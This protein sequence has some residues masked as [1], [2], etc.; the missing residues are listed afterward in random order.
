M[1]VIRTACIK[2]YLPEGATTLVVGGGLGPAVFRAGAR[3]G[4]LILFEVN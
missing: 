2:Y 4:S 3:A 1:E